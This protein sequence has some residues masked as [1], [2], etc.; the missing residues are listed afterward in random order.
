MFILRYGLNGFVKRSKKQFGLNPLY[1]VS[2]P[3]FTN[4]TIY[5]K[6]DIQMLKIKRLWQ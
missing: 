6:Q 3:D 4:A 1:Y 5:T 2:L